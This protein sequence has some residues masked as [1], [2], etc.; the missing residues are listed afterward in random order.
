M[1]LQDSLKVLQQ[2]IRNFQDNAKNKILNLSKYNIAVIK[3]NN[4]T[5][6]MILSMVLYHLRNTIK[7]LLKSK[8]KLKDFNKLQKTIKRFFQ[9]FI[10]TTELINFDKDTDLFKKLNENNSIS[11]FRILFSDI[12]KEKINKNVFEAKCNELKESIFNFS[13]F[14]EKY[15][16][17]HSKIQSFENLKENVENFQK[18]LNSGNLEKI[19]E[20]NLEDFRIF[21]SFFPLNINSEYL[22][23]IKNRTIIKL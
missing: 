23:D 12:F 22:I 21:R 9:K 15:K 8:I 10:D 18:I 17:F 4:E 11:A 19:N 2:E 13:N 1:Q 5:Q 7:E 14:K 3:P 20:E 6:V 16:E